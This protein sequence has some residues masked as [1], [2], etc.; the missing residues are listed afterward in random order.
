[1]S[2]EWS[3]S[4]ISEDLYALGRVVA[5]MIVAGYYTKFFLDSNESCNDMPQL[6][7]NFSDKMEDEL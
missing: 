1:M 4:K 2:E 5:A 7:P 3:I 6:R